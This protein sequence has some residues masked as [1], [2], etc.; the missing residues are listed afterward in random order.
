MRRPLLY[1]QERGSQPEAGERGSGHP[2][3]PHRLAEQDASPERL[4]PDVT[5]FPSRPLWCFGTPLGPGG[6]R[7]VAAVVVFWGE[8]GGGQGSSVQRAGHRRRAVL[9]H[10]KPA[11][12]LAFSPG[13]FPCQDGS[14][15]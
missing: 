13:A 14:R 8:S 5:W 9:G 2:V 10:A 3:P 15:R 11:L 4:F 7:G 12:R 6:A 1:L